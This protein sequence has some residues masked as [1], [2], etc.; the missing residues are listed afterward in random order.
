MQ[1]SPADIAD[2]FSILDLKLDR[3]P[4][5]EAAM[6]V[7]EHRAFMRA[8]L[9]QEIPVE[10]CARLKE[11]NGRI[12]DLEYDLRMGVLAEP[13]TQSEYAEIG[14][15]SIQIRNIN[16]ERVAAKN[17]ISKRLGGFFDVKMQHLSQSV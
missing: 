11:I 10:D 16:R 15:R 14:R 6:L 17:A 7:D 5:E 13:T 2:R 12:F 9:E 4:A 8:V 3:F 1:M